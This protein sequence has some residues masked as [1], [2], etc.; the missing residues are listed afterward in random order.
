M[1]RIRDMN[2]L[3]HTAHKATEPGP[4]KWQANAAWIEYMRGNAVL[5]T[6]ALLAIARWAQRPGGTTN[7]ELHR[8]AQA[9]P[10]FQKKEEAA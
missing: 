2:R 10:E 5:V 6:E 9:L 8:I 7:Q 4:D 3:L 1:T